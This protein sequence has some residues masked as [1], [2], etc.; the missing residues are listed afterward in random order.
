MSDIQALS[1]RELA[2]SIRR[3]D[4]SAREALASHLTRIDEVNPVINAIVTLDVET[5]EQRAMDADNEA[6]SGAVLPPLHGVPM[7][8]KDNHLTAG[9]RT[10]FGSPVMADNI[11]TEDS[12]IIAR[13]K[14]AGVNTT[15]KSNVPEFAAGSHTFNPLFGTTTNPYDPTR[16]AGGSSGGAAAAIAAG[17][18]PAG[19]GS[20]MGGSLRTPGS[21]CNLVGYRPSLGRIPM[22][23]ARNPWAWIARQ[24]VLAHDVEDVRFLMRSIAGPDASSP[25]SL[26]FDDSYVSEEPGN[27][28]GLRVAWTADFG[29]GVPVE[30]E[31]IEVLTRRLH[32]FEELGATVEVA[33]P[34][35][36]D[37]D[38]VF[39]TTRAFDFATNYGH[40]MADHRHRMK[41]AV[42][43]N[44]DK[45][46]SLTTPELFSANAARRR[47]DAATRSF[48]S[49]Y[50]VLIAPAVQVLPF[51]AVEEYPTVI[52]G[53]PMGNYLDWMRAACLISATGLPSLSVPGGFSSSGLPV[54][55]QI[56]AADRADRLL[57]RVAHAFEE[58]TG[59]YRRKPEL[60]AVAVPAV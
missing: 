52:D 44:V 12:G 38:E 5:A 7:T 10:T 43:W 26:P 53:T 57:L 31:V 42:Q 3:R 9:M 55:L 11:P 16:S 41:D 6:A 56:V 46:M 2:S 48:F 15:G 20:D 36:S 58:S 29:L 35:L 49:T 59:F 14:R 32:V 25:H 18:Q 21:F 45:G 34:D 30:R 39:Q 23:P 33:C 50:D 17:V 54:G 28:R 19:D 24:G 47:L 1:L 22:L 37:S 51:P 8:H 13:L 27:L 60:S 4:I 40:L